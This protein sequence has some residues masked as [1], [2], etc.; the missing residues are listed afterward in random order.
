[1]KETIYVGNLPRD[2]SDQD[3]GELFENFGKVLS[4][5]LVRYWDTGESRRFGF[6]VMYEEEVEIAIK[7]LNNMDIGRKRLKLDIAKKEK[8]EDKG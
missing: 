4:A 5:K 8:E 7:S 6:V 2:I 1:V 3:I